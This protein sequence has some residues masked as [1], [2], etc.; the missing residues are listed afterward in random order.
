MRNVWKGFVIGS[1]AGAAI[2]IILDKT[3]SEP[4]ERLAN[5]WKGLLIGSVAGSTVGIVLDS[6]SKASQRLVQ[7]ATEADF[8]AKASELRER[9]ADSQV[10][11]TATDRAHEIARTGADVLHQANEAISDIGSKSLAIMN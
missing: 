10:V 5:V 6:G 11:Q 9:A 4:S 8:G 1:A 7:A 3:R 2:G